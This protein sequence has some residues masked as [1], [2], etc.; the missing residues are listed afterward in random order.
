M[1]EKAN[2]PSFLLEHTP[3]LEEANPIWPA[4]SFVLHRN[5]ARYNFPPKLTETDGYQVLNLLKN[6]LLDSKL[7]QE[8]LFLKSEELSPLDKEFLFEHFLCL[9]GFQQPMKSQGFLVAEGAHLLGMMNVQD[10]LQLHMLDC[11]GGWESAYARLLA[12]DTFIGK[13]LEYAFSTKFG[14]LTADPKIAGTALLVRVFLHLPALIHTG[15]AIEKEEEVA[16]MSLQGS[17]ENSVG[18][19]VVLQNAF[20]LGLSEENILRSLHALSSKLISAESALRTELKTTNN[21]NMKD[22]VSRAFGL[23]LHSY[24]LQTKEALDALSLI[25]L[26][27]HL[28]WISG[29]SDT[30]INDIFF[31]C[32]HAHLSYLLQEKKIA[33][34]EALAHKRA[35][36]I[37]QQ[38]AGVTLQT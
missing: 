12:L 13:H 26:G 29:M 25:K 28:G 5:L 4:T 38:L 15:K 35:E 2:L 31:K 20:T 34:P 21:A 3:W 18:D 16:L 23:L 30:K 8:S 10:H 7:L 6:T 19:I 32:R 11:I 14:Y 27:I 24:Q 33:T 37:H 17:L 36:F 1:K 9:E 22:Q